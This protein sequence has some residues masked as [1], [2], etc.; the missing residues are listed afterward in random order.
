MVDMDRHLLKRGEEKARAVAAIEG[1]LKA[2]ESEEREPD[3]W[4]RVFLV[5]AVGALF[6]GIYSLGV[7]DAHLALTPMAERSRD[8]HLP[9][10]P[11]FE[12]YDLKTLRAALDEARA[13]PLRAHPH[14][15]PVIFVDQDGKQVE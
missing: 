6:R 7:V 12:R 10:D 2:I 1:A 3:L 4:E 14:F 11:F 8:A 9:D 5:Q 15:G 13:E